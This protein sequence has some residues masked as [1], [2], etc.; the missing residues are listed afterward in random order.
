MFVQHDATDTVA[1]CSLFITL[2]CAYV[3]TLNNAEQKLDVSVTADLTTR[4]S[5]WKVMVKKK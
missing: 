5:I 4:V 1:K 2:A 3:V